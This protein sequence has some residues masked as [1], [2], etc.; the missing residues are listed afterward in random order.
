MVEMSLGLEVALVMGIAGMG[1]LAL[2]WSA[3]ELVQSRR[4]L[5]EAT[6]RLLGVGNE[7]GPGESLVPGSSELTMSPAPVRLRASA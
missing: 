6:R 1:I 4:A 2:P 3:G 5:R 7:G